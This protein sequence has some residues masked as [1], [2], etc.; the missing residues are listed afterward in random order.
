[1]TVD[2]LPIL[3]EDLSAD[4]LFVN[5][6]LD[7]A[8]ERFANQD[9][10]TFAVENNPSEDAE[11][12]HYSG[13]VEDGIKDRLKIREKALKYEQIRMSDRLVLPEEDLTFENED[14][15][16]KNGSNMEMEVM[17]Q[18]RSQK[19]ALDA[20][21]LENITTVLRKLLNQTGLGKYAYYMNI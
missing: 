8:A 18:E 14:Y 4:K 21:T 15:I 11:L 6:S 17:R 16:L 7:A 13:A 12:L 3:G 19:D 1:M 5:H 2:K 10:E 20:L 9:V